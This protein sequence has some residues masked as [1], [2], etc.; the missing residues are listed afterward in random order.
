MHILQE[1]VDPI[2]DDLYG[3]APSLKSCSLA[4]RIF[5]ASAQT[6]VFNKIEI[7][8]PSRNANGSRDSP[9]EKFYKLLTSSP[10]LAPHV[11]ELHV[12]VGSE[13]SFAYNEEHCRYLERH[14]IP[15]VMSRRTVLGLF[16][17]I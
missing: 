2:V 13:T 15:W 16:L 17:S 3:D 4:A 14:S 10:H 6:C 5:V 11:D 12:L 9:W 8:P 7:L 1:L